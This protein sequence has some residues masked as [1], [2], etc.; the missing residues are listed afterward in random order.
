MAALFYKSTSEK[1]WKTRKRASTRV[2][3]WADIVEYDDTHMPFKKSRGWSP[4][5]P[6]TKITNHYSRFSTTNAY[7]T[8]RIPQSHCIRTL[9]LFGTQWSLRRRKIEKLYYPGR[10]CQIRESSWNGQ[11]SLSVDFNYTTAYDMYSSFDTSIK[12][13]KFF[14]ICLN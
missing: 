9:T 8:I 13:E 11:A 14:E 1:G 5:T 4:F 6:P 3:G 12:R 7:K 10:V 2:R